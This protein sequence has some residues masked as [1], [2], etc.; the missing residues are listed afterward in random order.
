MREARLRWVTRAIWWESFREICVIDPY[1]SLGY[2]YIRH[3]GVFGGALMDFDSKLIIYT[4]RVLIE[5]NVWC[6]SDFATPK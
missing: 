4:H 2:K 6:T 3:L 1:C 5:W